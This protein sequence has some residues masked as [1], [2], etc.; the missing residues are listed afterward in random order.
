VVDSRLAFCGYINACWTILT[1]TTTCWRLRGLTLQLLAT[2]SVALTEAMELLWW[3]VQGRLQRQ[4]T[5]SVPLG[6]FKAAGWRV[7]QRRP[8]QA[9]Q[10]P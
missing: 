2:G 5:T 3:R 10:C 1:P 9:R 6:K 4:Q 7:D 8:R